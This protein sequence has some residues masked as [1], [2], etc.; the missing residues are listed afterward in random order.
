MAGC[1]RSLYP[2]LVGLADQASVNFRKKCLIKS[3]TVSVNLEERCIGNNPS[4]YKI[5]NSFSCKI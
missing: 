2:C 3:N 1:V 5:R 4:I